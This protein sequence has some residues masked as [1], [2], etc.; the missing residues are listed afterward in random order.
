MSNETVSE[1]DDIDIH[2]KSGDMRLTVSPTGAS[3]RGLSRI[4]DTAEVEIV[5]EYRGA[6]NKH[7]ETTRGLS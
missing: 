3:L 1:I 4:N 6:G 7:G 2:L 5:T